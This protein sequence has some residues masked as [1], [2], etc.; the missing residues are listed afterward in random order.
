MKYLIIL[1]ALITFSTSL[2][3][4]QS[5]GTTLQHGDPSKTRQIL[6][7][8]KPPSFNDGQGTQDPNGGNNF[9]RAPHQNQTLSTTNDEGWFQEDG[10]GNPLPNVVLLKQG[11]QSTVIRRYRS[12]KGNP[13]RLWVTDNAGT[14]PVPLATREQFDNF[15]THM[16]NRETQGK[17][18]C[19]IV[20]NP[21][22]NWAPVGA[23][24]TG[25]GLQTYTE[26]RQC[27]AATLADKPCPDACGGQAQQTRTA[28]VN[29]GPCNQPPSVSLSAS[30]AG[31]GTT[32]FSATVGGSDPEGS[33]LQYLIT[34]SGAC[35]GLSNVG[36]WS[37][38][39]TATIRRQGTGTCTVYGYTNDFITS[40]G[41]AVR[42]GQVTAFCNANAWTAPGGVAVST[43]AASCNTPGTFTITNACGTPSSANCTGVPCDPNAWTPNPATTAPTCNIPGTFTI[44]NACGT[45]SSANCT[46]VPCD[47]NA[48]TAPGGQ[49]VATYAAGCFSPNTFTSTNACGDP[50]TDSCT[51][52]ACDPSAW[53]APDGRSPAAYAADCNSPSQFTITNECGSPKPYSCTGVA[54]PPPPVTGRWSSIQWV[55]DQC[56]HLVSNA[57][58]AQWPIG[59]ARPVGGSC[60]PIGSTAQS[61]GIVAGTTP[62]TGAPCHVFYR[63]FRQSCN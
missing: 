27:L 58:K 49:N 56:S 1:V 37:A 25:C 45:P 7:A 35:V 46:G 38:N 57:T 18:W 63:F 2:V 23:V 48:W 4:E 55:G 36:T 8:H 22:G 3:A 5:P 31:M 17:H 33:S 54:T 34:V 12:A 16:G 15:L 39:R 21:W 6:D 11:D 29:N 59:G 20:E 28:S 19:E 53:R 50:R 60:S 30:P 24:P 42:S 62:T 47:A 10:A 52:V 13:Y 14:F 26:A 41:P 9:E 40:A 44:T 61:G 51:A 32:T 43:Y